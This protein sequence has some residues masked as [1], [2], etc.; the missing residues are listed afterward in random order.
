MAIGNT[1]STYTP[2][3]KQ[4]YAK[5]PVENETYLRNPLYA[6]MPKNEG[7]TGLTFEQPVIYGAGQGR[8]RTFSTAQT[9]GSLTSDGSVRFSIPRVT[10]W[11][12]STLDLQT[13]LAS[14]NDEGA[15]MKA[16]TE[17]V[18]NNLRNLANNLSVSLYGTGSGARGQVGN[19]SFSTSVLTF[20]TP[21]DALKF[22]VGMQLDVAAA[23]TTGNVRA[24][25][26]AGHGLYVVAVDRNANTV[27]VGVSPVQGASTC[28]LSDATNGIPTIAQ[29]DFIFVTGDRNLSVVGV[30]GW[31]PYGGP[32]AGDSFFG[33]NRTVDPVRLAGLSMDGT[34]F[35][36][37]EEALIEAVNRVAEQDGEISHFFVPFKKFSD[38]SKS[39]SAKMVVINPQDAPQIGFTALEVAG[40]AGMV[41][42]VPDRNCPA[43]RIF[44]LKLD[45]WQINSINKAVHPFDEDGNVWLRQASDGGLEFR[46]YSLCN[47]SCR[48]PR[49][50]IVIN[51]NP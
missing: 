19:S 25:G 40:P 3:L 8:S 7:V 34:V 9:M 4:F 12:D 43:N 16:S 5:K 21:K 32:S 41:K 38:L 18:D 30:G 42:I 48:E 22:E 24:Y 49:S 6:M 37:I 35:P 36:M 44:G 31:C 1:T 51:V 46:S 10:D 15:F 50:N 17:I 27:T 39:L 11:A 14:V 47:V 33:V 20:V 28:N 45:T 2:L 23:E 13:Y 29:N 26:S